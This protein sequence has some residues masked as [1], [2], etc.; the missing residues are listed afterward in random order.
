MI[1]KFIFFNKIIILFTIRKMA[2]PHGR[3]KSPLHFKTNSSYETKNPA[4]NGAYHPKTF[5]F[6]IKSFGITI[7][8]IKNP[9]LSDFDASQTIDKKEAIYLGLAMSA[10][11]FV[12]SMGISML[13]NF[14]ILFPLLVA[15]FQLVFL[16]FGNYFGKRIT[17]VSHL[18][19]SIW[20]RISGI[21]LMLLSVLKLF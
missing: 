12:S 18:S 1:N 14:S 3:L 5:Q 2:L 8:I 19:P 13:G 16:S 15:T 20:S 4:S 7:K 17:A 10:D 11:S 9:I 21:L 6:F